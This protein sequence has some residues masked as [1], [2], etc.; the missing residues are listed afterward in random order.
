MN[1]YQPE[2]NWELSVLSF[3]DDPNLYLFTPTATTGLNEEPHMSVSPK[4]GHGCPTIGEVTYVNNDLLARKSVIEQNV[5]TAKFF[6][7]VILFTTILDLL[8]L[9]SSLLIANRISL[10]KTFIFCG[11]LGIVFIWALMILGPIT[12]LLF[13]CMVRLTVQAELTNISEVGAQYF[14]AS[15]ILALITLLLIVLRYVLFRDILFIAPSK[16]ATSQPPLSTP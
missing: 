15:I 4:N 2:F 14:L 16:A 12:D 11:L 5:E 13:A 1:Q 3:D 7:G 10:L 6:L 8:V 9:A